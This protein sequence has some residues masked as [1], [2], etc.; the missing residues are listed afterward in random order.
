MELIGRTGVRGPMGIVTIDV[1][2][3]AAKQAGRHHGCKVRMLAPVLICIMAFV[4]CRTPPELGH[5]AK[6]P[7]GEAHG[8]GTTI[9]GLVV[10]MDEDGNLMTNIPYRW[11]AAKRT[12]KDPLH[13]DKGFGPETNPLIVSIGSREFTGAFVCEKKAAAPGWVVVAVGS[14]GKVCRWD[15]PTML[16]RIDLKGGSAAKVSG[17]TVGTVVRLTKKDYP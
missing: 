10:K 15:P 2:R 5:A 4:G 8:D 16:L 14:D 1:G 9:V 6:L 12:D 11:N 13:G 7:H 3:N 17:A